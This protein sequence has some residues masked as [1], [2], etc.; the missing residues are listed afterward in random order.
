MPSNT[1]WRGTQRGIGAEAKIFIRKKK[2][3]KRENGRGRL[4][5]LIDPYT[6]CVTAVEKKKGRRIQLGGCSIHT[7]FVLRKSR[8]CVDVLI[9]CILYSGYKSHDYIVYIPAAKSKQHTNTVSVNNVCIKLAMPHFLIT[10]SFNRS[11][12][13][14]GRLDVYVQ[15]CFMN[16]RSCI[17]RQKCQKQT[18]V[19]ETKRKVCDLQTLKTTRGKSW[20]YMR[21]QNVYTHQHIC[22]K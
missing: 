20:L 8:H 1:S 17:H 15:Q 4:A 11:G 6:I 5:F 22:K 13:G 2:E 3:K 18:D 9:K 7:D 19:E 12:G 10:L 14:G 16:N 21:Y